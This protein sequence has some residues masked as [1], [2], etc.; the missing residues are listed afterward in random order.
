MITGAAAGI[1]GMLSG[2]GMMTL[3]AKSSTEKLE[4]RLGVLEAK[5]LVLKDS[6]H[7][8]RSEV[9][10]AMTGLA[11]QMQLAL[12]QQGEGMALLV[13]QLE[14]SNAANAKAVRIAEARAQAT[15]PSNGAMSAQ[16]QQQM[17][18]QLENLQRQIGG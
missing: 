12:N 6:E 11:E 17:M 8:T 16:V 10:T 4:E 7:I 15:A 1:I 13:Q 9:Q 14:Q 5:E 2:Q 3:L 18:N